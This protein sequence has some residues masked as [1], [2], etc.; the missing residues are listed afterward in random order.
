MNI[1]VIFA[2]G[3]G[4][5]MRSKDKPKQFLE[6]FGKPIII[7]TLE[8]F[9]NNADIDAVVISCVEEWIDYLRSQID[10]FG[11]TKVRKI[12]AGGSSGQLSI[13]NGLCAARDVAGSE[14]A[15]VL[16]HDGVRPL[17]NS[18]LLSENIACVKAHGS[19]ITAGIVKET[20][21]VT[22]KDGCVEQVPL[23]DNSRVA[24][25]PQSFYLDDILTAHEKAM[26][27]NVYDTVDS[28]TLMNRYG[29]KLYMVDGPYDNIKITTPDDYYAMRAI[30]EAKENAQIYGAEE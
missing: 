3:V 15:I 22:D 26:S 1:G 30:L 9:E 29:Y 10:K 23:R 19:A 6:I 13:Y 5:R 27:D 8:H 14:K 24:K 18:K 12:V 20:I 11:I 7:H 4:S 2:G 17:I 25:A 28:C 16:I 21:V